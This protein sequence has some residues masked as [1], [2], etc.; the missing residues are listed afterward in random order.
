MKEKWRFS[1]DGLPMTDFYVITFFFF[2]VRITDT[3]LDF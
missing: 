3:H 2:S 1:L